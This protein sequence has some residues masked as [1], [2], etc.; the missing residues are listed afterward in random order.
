M[1]SVK[2]KRMLFYHRKKRIHVLK[3]VGLVT[4][5]ARNS[6]GRPK[7]TRLRNDDSG[8]CNC[9][10][11]GIERSTCSVATMWPADATAFSLSSPPPHF[12][13]SF[14]F[15]SIGRPANKCRSY[16]D[17]TGNWARGRVA[18]AAGCSRLTAGCNNDN[19]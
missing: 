17:C 4:L 14:S 1:L 3:R 10:P 19:G 6:C 5:A 2:S 16:T 12:S 15:S 7:I 9:P 8:G 18:L 11:P 13:L